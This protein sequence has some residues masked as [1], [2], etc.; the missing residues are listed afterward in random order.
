MATAVLAA[1]ILTAVPTLPKADG[2]DHTADQIRLSI[3]HQIREHR[4][5]VHKVRRER[6]RAA[7]KAAQ[8]ALPYAAPYTPPSIA[9]PAYPAGV[10]SAAQVASYATAAG[11][12]SSVVPTMV[13]IAYRESRFDPNAVN[14]SSGA[15]GLWQIFPGG[16]QYLDP[17]ANAAAA[18]AKYEASGLSPWGM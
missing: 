11:F 2:I 1:A 17:A 5:F 16:S 15:T 10:L 13:A 6:R 18:Y 9:P 8:A 7:Q 4:A 3:V 12:P 14:A